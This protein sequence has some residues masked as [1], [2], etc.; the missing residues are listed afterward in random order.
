MLVVAEDA[1]RASSGC[2]VA[3]DKPHVARAQRLDAGTKHTAAQ[4]EGAAL[5]PERTT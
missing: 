4:Y 1:V 2:K 5:I 3:V